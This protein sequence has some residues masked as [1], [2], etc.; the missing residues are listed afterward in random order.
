MEMVEAAESVITGL[1][2]KL[3]NELQTYQ[4]EQQGEL[5]SVQAAHIYLEHLRASFGRKGT[6]FSE[7]MGFLPVGRMSEVDAKMAAQLLVPF[8]S[9]AFVE[10]VASGLQSISNSARS[11]VWRCEKHVVELIRKSADA[12]PEDIQTMLKDYFHKEHYILQSLLE[13]VEKAV[14]GML[15]ATPG[16]PSTKAIWNDLVNALLQ[17][18]KRGLDQAVEEILESKFESFCG[19]D[20]LEFFILEQALPMLNSTANGL[21]HLAAFAKEKVPDVAPQVAEST[22]WLGEIVGGLVGALEGEA[23]IWFEKVCGL[24]GAVA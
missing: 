8:R 4:A 5:Q 12:T 9:R 10:S 14:R 3:S 6:V 22:E 15:T 7:M 16:N 19:R 17:K 11:L 24:V 13:T 2:S 21:P 18:T 20:G 1:G 23:R